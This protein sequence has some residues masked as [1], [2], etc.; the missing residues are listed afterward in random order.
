MAQR[1]I[2]TG[3]AC[4]VVVEEVPVWVWARLNDARRGGWTAALHCRRRMAAMKS[5]KSCPEVTWLD[6]ETLVA[7]LG[8][9]F[10]L[11]KL[12]RRCQCPRC[13]TK[14]VDLEWIVP[15][16]ASST[17]TVPGSS[18]EQLREDE[19]RRRRHERASLTEQ[20]L[21]PLQKSG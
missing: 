16:A 20:A 21:S 14:H 18:I 8:E 6:I 15:A 12:M 13:G 10:P 9:D 7:A 11:E 5:S 3:S 17:A 4:S 19:E 1:Y 2:G